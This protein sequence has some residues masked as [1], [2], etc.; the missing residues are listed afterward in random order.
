[1]KAMQ[2]TALVLALSAGL[3]L[4][5]SMSLADE[6]P[7]K[8]AHATHHVDATPAPAP[9]DMQAMRNRMRE[10]HQTA[11]PDK[12]NTLIEA[13][14]KDMEAMMRDPNRNCPMAP[15]DETRR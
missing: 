7:A 10:I 9:I 15:D 4:P 2:R 14:L 8:D 13:Q 6:A 5:A 3:I 11:D 1:M 12:R